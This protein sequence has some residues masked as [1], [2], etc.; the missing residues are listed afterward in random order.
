M[1]DTPHYASWAEVPAGLRPENDLRF[2]GLEPR[3]EPAAWLLLGDREVALFREADAVPRAPK[4]PPARGSVDPSRSSDR[5]P[6]SA[7]TRGTGVRRDV[8]VLP[9]TGS[10]RR[11][12]VRA[13]ADPATTT[14][15]A[16]TWIRELLKDDFLVLDTETT[17]LGYGAE[18]IEIGVIGPDG[19]ERLSSLVRPRAGHVP[20]AVTAIHGITMDHLRGAPTFAEVYDALLELARGRRVVAWNAPFDERMVRQSATAWGRR[21]RLTGFEC[22]M[23]A[24][25]LAR[26]LRQGRAK[27]E[28]A[29]AETGVLTAGRQSHRSSD[30]A[31]LTLQVL[32][33]VAGGR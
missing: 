18:V 12:V 19:R 24:Y 9:G 25:A 5:P 11:G 1:R 31:R 26:G 8:V 2:A 7:G 21:E 17:G 14:D 6:G 10:L 13:D 28:R 32:M 30:D 20:A 4:P 23:R 29:A 16:R 27:L 15:A 3:G 33:R 22:A